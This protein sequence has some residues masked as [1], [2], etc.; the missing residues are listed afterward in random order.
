M[1]RIA[2]LSVALLLA[3]AGTAHGQSSRGLPGQSCESGDLSSC[4]ILG[5]VYE[6]GAAGRRD[7]AR[8]IELYRRACER[9]VA[10]GCQRLAFTTQRPRVELPEDDFVRIGRVADSETGAPVAEAVIFLPDLDVRV[11]A[12]DAGRVDLGRLPRGRHRIIA[13]RFGYER[14]DGDLPVPWDSEFLL[15]MPPTTGVDA[16]TVGRVFGQVTEEGTGR[17]LSA[18]EVLLVSGQPIGTTTNPDGR[19]GAR[20][21]ASRRAAPGDPRSA[22]QGHS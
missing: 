8:A 15:F 11:V 18:V 13:Q 12:D 19:P 7:V 3:C 21:A 14:V 20:I 17:G 10:A 4:P 6:T 2:L 22:Q 1:S 5:L 16:P 9:D